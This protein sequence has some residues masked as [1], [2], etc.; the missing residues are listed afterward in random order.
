MFEANSMFNEILHWAVL[1][2]GVVGVVV[3]VWGVAGAA[4]RL[5][6]ASLPPRERGATVRESIRHELGFHLVLGLELLVAA[7]I[8]ETL[9]A[10]TLERVGLLAAIVLIRTLISFSLNWELSRASHHTTAADAR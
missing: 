4:W 9:I 8:I 7:D 10:P 3:M 2:I 1:A 6:R 5:V